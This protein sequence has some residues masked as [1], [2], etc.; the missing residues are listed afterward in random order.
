[1]NCALA[2]SM[3][4]SLNSDHPNENKIPWPHR[5]RGEMHTTTPRGCGETLPASLNRFNWHNQS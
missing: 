1:L 2:R 5:L 3:P 4:A